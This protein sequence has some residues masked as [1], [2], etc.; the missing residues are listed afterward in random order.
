M[1]PKLDMPIAQTDILQKA[2]D[3]EVRTSVREI[4]ERLQDVLSQRYIAY[5][6]NVRSAKSVAHWAAGKKPGDDAE[7]RL[8]ALFRVV[9]VLDAEDDDTKRAWLLGSNPGLDDHAPLD[10]VREGLFSAVV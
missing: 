1:R 3:R 8:R 10:L 5:A 2:H 7:H 4:V 9:L 6:A